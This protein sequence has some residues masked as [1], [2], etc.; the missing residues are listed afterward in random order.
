MKN[1]VASLALAGAM[2]LLSLDAAAQA[3]ADACG[4]IE[5][6]SISECHF[7]FSG[8]CKAKCE[9]L[10]FTA[11]CDGQ[12]NASI[13]ATCNSS[14][15]AD[16]AAE[17]NI[18]PGAFDCRASCTADC[19]ARTAAQC[20]DDQDCITYCEA[21]CSS[22]CEAE[23]N[24]VPPSADC[25]AQCSACCTGTCDV[26]ANFDCS[27][28]CSADLRGGCEVDCDAPEGA[29]FCDG[30]YIAV[31]DLPA[32][33]QYLLENFDIQLE[34]EAQASFGPDGFNSSSSGCAMTDRHT[35]PGGFAALLAGLGFV[36]WRRRRRF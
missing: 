27:L 10:R 19:N 28:S 35:G 21:D 31:Q 23:C 14:C 25:E 18:D 26:D 1:H 7:E 29:L 32:C 30:Q 17:C 6:T 34:V 24:I 13:D 3:S 33:A 36:S 9:P 22:Q 4:G 12:C 15:D 2:S 16:C 5:L 8:G 11:A 20:G